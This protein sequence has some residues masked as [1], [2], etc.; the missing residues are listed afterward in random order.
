MFMAILTLLTALSISAVAIYYSILGLAAIF[1]G[2]AIPIMVMGSVLEVGKLVTASWLYQN[3]KVAPKFIKAYLS[4]AVVV[5][6]FI[7]SMGIFGFLSKAHVEQTSLGTIGTEKLATIEEKLLRSENRID[8]WSSDI[9]RLV[10][11]EDVRVDILIDKEQV[12]LDKLYARIDV[13]KQAL[14]DQADKD[15]E[16]Q[17]N[18]LKQAQERKEA[19]I[20]AAQERFKGAFSKKGLDEAIAKATANELSVASAA[21]KLI[22]KIQNKLKEDLA[23]VDAKYVDQITSIEKIINNYKS[24]ANTKTGDI[25]G[26]I[27][28]LEDQIEAEQDK[29][30]QVNEDKIVLMS[31]QA[32]LEVEVGPLKYIAEFVYGQEANQ[33]LLEAA[34]RW[35]IIIIIVV[36]DPLA[37]LLLIAANMSLIRRFGRG[38]EKQYDPDLV[39]KYSGPDQKQNEVKDLKKRHEKELNE[40]REKLSETKEELQ[41]Q[42]DYQK[43]L[44]EKP[45]KTVINIDETIN[46]KPGDQVKKKK[47]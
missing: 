35:V 28:A 36:F 5:L 39:K 19:D 24:Q 27:I 34:V 10:S 1:A 4:I 20:A 45:N 46:V 22:V 37:V 25:E 43:S 12:E 9:E 33:N 29:I 41:E 17:N 30:D 6:M 47:D 7:T 32:Q 23:G 40:F 44:E 16:L 26:K 18:R 2:A 42:L 14:R 3:W 8:R 15:I 31:K 13:E 21:Q 38:F 11:G